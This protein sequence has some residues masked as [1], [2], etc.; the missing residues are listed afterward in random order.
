MKQTRT[1]HEKKLQESALPGQPYSWRRF[2]DRNR[3]NCQPTPKPQN[4]WW[5]QRIIDLRKMHW[6]VRI[7]RPLHTGQD[8]EQTS[9]V[10][11]SP[12]A[13]AQLSQHTVLVTVAVPVLAQVPCCS[14]SEARFCLSSLLRLSTA[15]WNSCPGS[16][17]CTFF[18]W[19][20]FT[21]GN[22]YFETQKLYTPNQQD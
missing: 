15:S 12:K 17:S 13:F 2:R 18:Q 7:I 11:D 21:G 9:E 4:G 1:L 10:C 3:F 22:P 16:C 8:E 14:R 19:I 6:Q 5:G 20:Q